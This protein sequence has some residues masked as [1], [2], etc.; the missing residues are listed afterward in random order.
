MPVRRIGVRLL[1]GGGPEDL[2]KQEK[3]TRSK[4]LQIALSR[5]RRAM[6]FGR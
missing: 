3:G 5:R 1:V 6:L 2:L 4:M